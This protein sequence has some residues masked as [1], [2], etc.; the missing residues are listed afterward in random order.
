MVSDNRRA[1]QVAPRARKHLDRQDSKHKKHGKGG[2]HEWLY[3]RVQSEESGMH[4]ETPTG[5][6]TNRT[7]CKRRRLPRIVEH[8]G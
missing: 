1:G 3:V 7:L 6:A 8:V 4:M 5:D 2:W